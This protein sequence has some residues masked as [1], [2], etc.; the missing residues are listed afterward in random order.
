MLLCDVDG[1]LTD[2]KV[3]IG[4]GLEAKSF[5]IQDGL[6]L[7]VLS[8]AGILVGWISN[9]PS[10][11][12]TL[13]AEELRIDFLTQEKKGKVV[14]AEELLAQAKLRWSQVC[15][16]GDDLV[17]LGPMRRAGVGVAVANSVAEVIAVAHYVTRA[18]G[19]DGAVREVCELVLRAQ[20]LWDDILKTYTA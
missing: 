12:T 7:A 3:L 4:K 11:A 19:G 18:E 15:Y 20:D 1:V 9:R 17:D 13:R 6:G 8:K 5:S 2:G 16:M 10:T 14:L